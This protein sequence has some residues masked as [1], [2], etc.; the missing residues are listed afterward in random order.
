MVLALGDSLVGGLVGSWWGFGGP[1]N[2]LGGGLVGGLPI[3]GEQD[4]RKW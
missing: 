3:K 1:C 4:G 2:L